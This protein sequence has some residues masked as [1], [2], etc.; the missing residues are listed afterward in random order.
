MKGI[1]EIRQRIR[2]VKNTSQ[3]TKALQLVAS[4]KM[5][6]AQDAAIAGRA[7]AALLAQ[8]M[9]SLADKVGVAN[10]PLFLPRPVAK[11]G[12]VL[13]ST[14][15]GLCGPLNSNLFRQVAEIPS[16]QARFIS[17]GRKGTQY[18][19][20]TGRDLLADFSVSDRVGYNEVRPVVEFVTQAY[21]DGK[22]DTVEVLYSSFVNTLRQEPLL[23]PL[24]PFTSLRETIDRLR[25]KLGQA[26]TIEAPDNGAQ[27]L[28]EPSP[29]EILDL[30]PP[31]FLKQEIYQMLLGAKASEHSARMVAMKSASD[32]A[33]QIVGDLTLEYNKARQASITQEILEIAAASATSD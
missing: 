17:V 28:F 4:S 27:M 21:L 19:A 8:M 15:K 2:A 7:Y 20:R 9:E 13:I 12:I 23:I 18:L 6:R 24:V 3:I 1:R 16:Q 32:N 33:K 5:K 30:L 14:D 11:R 26:S 22:I 31:L 29:E 10:H 25:E